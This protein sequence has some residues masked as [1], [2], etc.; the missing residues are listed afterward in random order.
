MQAVKE[1]PNLSRFV[2][3]S[4]GQEQ[5][6]PDLLDKKSLKQLEISVADDE[7]FLEILEK[8]KSNTHLIELDIIG[9]SPV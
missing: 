4:K 9:S 5:S 3:Y 1:L 7:V 8:L 2:L 6:Y